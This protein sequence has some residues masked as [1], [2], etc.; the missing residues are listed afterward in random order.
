M[1]V[2]DIDRTR[3]SVRRPALAPAARR[4]VA[5]LALLGLVALVVPA[6]VFAGDTGPSRLDL[7]VEKAVVEN[8]PGGSYDV[9]RGIDWLGEPVGRALLL[10]AVTLACWLAGRR[11]LA[12]AAVVSMIL[13]T[14]LAT[15]IKPFVD[16][17]IHAGFLSYPSGHTAALT[18]A[19]LIVGILLAD[20][21]GL[22]PIAGT[23]VMLGVT[24]AGAAVTSWAQII[25]DAHYPTDTVG[26]LGLALVVVPVTALLTDAVLRRTGGRRA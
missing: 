9:I 22:G 1:A 10:V 24:V 12:A 18:A 14:G 4:P 7:R 6:L 20:V 23:A 19:A 16:R 21:L 13:V 15:A 2:D 3:V 8:A 25:L 11:A 26:G 5:A 17:R